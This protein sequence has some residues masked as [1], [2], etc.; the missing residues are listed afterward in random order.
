[1]TNK[2]R[3]EDNESCVLFT[4]YF[5]DDNMVVVGSYS[6]TPSSS[7]LSSTHRQSSQHV[8]PHCFPFCSH[9]FTLVLILFIVSFSLFAP[10]RSNSRPILANTSVPVA[11]FAPFC[12]ACGLSI[13]S[14]FNYGKILR[15]L[16]PQ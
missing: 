8:F 1:M 13:N 14:S 7:S 6:S 12:S 9:V 15:M 3:L 16:L 2:V 10:S 11:H 5:I 4:I